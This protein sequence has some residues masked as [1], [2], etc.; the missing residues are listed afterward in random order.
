MIKD[1][2]SGFGLAGTLDWICLDVLQRFQQPPISLW[3]LKKVWVLQGLTY[4][5]R[6]VNAQ[7][8]CGSFLS[9]GTMAIDSFELWN[10]TR[11]VSHNLGQLDLRILA[12]TAGCPDLIKALS[13]GLGS[14]TF[15][16]FE[17]QQKIS[18]WHITQGK[19]WSAQ[20]ICTNVRLLLL[21]Q[22]CTSDSA[23]RQVLTCT[24]TPQCRCDPWGQKMWG[25]QCRFPLEG[26]NGTCESA[27][28]C[29]LAISMPYL[30][31]VNRSFR[32]PHL[33]EA[34]DAGKISLEAERLKSAA[35]QFLDVFGIS[36]DMMQLMHT[37]ART[38]A[39]WISES[40]VCKMDNVHC[41]LISKNLQ[42]SSTKIFTFVENL[43][44]FS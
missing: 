34:I 31:M 16:L 8:Q 40:K 35:S 2:F 33:Q 11:I 15:F 26:I 17:G 4:P 24:P 20:P 19:R 7:F 27:G 41:L 6:K 37:Y 29:T 18:A 32:Y 1:W 44:P 21:L 9:A 30:A 43:R 10:A 42:T 13:S 5:P 23:L 28:T 38:A 36:W 39:P 12:H 22:C 3:M 25:E 14:A